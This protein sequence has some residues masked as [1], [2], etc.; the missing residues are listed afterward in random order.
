[1]SVSWKA[2]AGSRTIFCTCGSDANDGHHSFTD[3]RQHLREYLQK[4]RETGR[5][6][7]VTT[8]GKTDAVVLSPEAFDRLME[9][10]ELGESLSMLEA[11]QADIAEG[12]TED[13]EV[14]FE[15]TA[16][17]LGLDPDAEP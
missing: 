9:R 2:R 13:A 6:L 15:R 12:R 7:Y 11:S 17:E 3:L 5:P 8:N 14:V 4:A 16:A 1:M 10:A